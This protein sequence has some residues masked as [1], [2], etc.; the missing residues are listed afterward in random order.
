LEYG[1][2]FRS[3]SRSRIFNE[4]EDSLRRLKT[5]TIDLDQVHWPDPKILV[6]E[7]AAVLAELCRGGKIRAFGVS[8]FTPTQMH[9]FRAVAHGAAAVQ[10]SNGASSVMSCPTTSNRTM[11][12][13]QIVTRSIR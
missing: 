6:G 5:D 3:A 2:P 7:T 4:V 8:N 10:C 1:Q 13:I 11:T 9:A 12:E